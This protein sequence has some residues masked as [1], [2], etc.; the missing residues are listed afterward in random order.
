MGEPSSV[1]TIIGRYALHGVIAKGGMAA[2]H[3]GRLMGLAGFSRT[4]AIKRLHPEFASDPEF[5]SMLMDEARIAARIRHPNVVA[6]LD[7][8]AL[9]GELLLVME[10]VHGE[11]LA[12][13]L[14]QAWAQGQ[15][16]PLPVVL[17]IF[18]GVLLGLQAAHEA[19]DERGEP[20]R[21]VHRD[22]APHNVHV[23]VDGVARLLDFGVAKAKGRLQTT[24]DGKLKGR[25]RYMAPEQLIPSAVVDLRADLYSTSV[26]LWEALTGR[27]LIDGES[28]W[29]QAHQSIAGV[30]T[31]PSALVPTVPPQLEA[32]VMKGLAKDVEDRFQSAADMAL[33]LEKLGSTA[34][35]REVGE[36]VRLHAEEA[37]GIRARMVE[38]VE[39]SA[40]VP[41]SKPYDMMRPPS[42]RA[43]PEARPSPAETEAA[44]PPNSQSPTA[45]EVKLRT[46]AEP[47]A[48]T[49]LVRGALVLAALVAAAAVTANVMWT[50]SHTRLRARGMNLHLV[51]AAAARLITAPMPT[52][53]ESVSTNEPEP[54]LH[55][56]PAL[57]SF[58]TASSSSVMA[59]PAVTTHIASASSKRRPGVVLPP[60]ASATA[61]ASPS[62]SPP[63][64]FDGTGV[65]HLKRECL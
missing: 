58:E 16:P 35:A 31:P 39:C 12:R 56:G 54:V 2:V 43:L 10:Y 60:R 36:W 44:P 37:L 34:S 27:R 3:L 62:C 33:A 61:S 6:M 25:L 14:S 21:L 11:S 29:Q 41:S 51:A 15:P 9:R 45:R 8:V 65:K 46:A 48:K 19:R 17:A 53:S 28:D 59:Q 1:H 5:V 63:F 40:L 57:G 18:E 13:L 32:I 64:Y 26:V 42:S 49:R 24:R 7:V 52:A 23:G 47:T 30:I 20:L 50:R 22:I 55:P 38:E 4:V